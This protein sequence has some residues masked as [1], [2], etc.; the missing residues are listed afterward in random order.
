MAR[1]SDVGE[2]GVRYELEVG[3]YANH[4]PDLG[5]HFP[6]YLTQRLTALIDGMG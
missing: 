4:V 2:L 5:V 3:E 1:T 6:D